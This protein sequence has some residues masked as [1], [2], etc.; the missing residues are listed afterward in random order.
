MYLLAQTLDL[1]ETFVAFGLHL[2]ELGL[3]L[4]VLRD[5]HVDF[6]FQNPILG[7]S[8][9]ELARNGDQPIRERADRFI[10]RFGLFARD[11]RRKLAIF[12]PK[13]DDPSEAA[14]AQ[15]GEDRNKE[16]F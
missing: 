5:G 3:H 6:G 8:L 1:F 4:A 9:I 10:D 2:V 13:L 14:A 16:F 7:Q 15:K 12:E 11:L